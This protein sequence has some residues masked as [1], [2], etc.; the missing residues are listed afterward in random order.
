MTTTTDYWIE[1]TAFHEAGHTVM[2]LDLGWPIDFVSIIRKGDSGGR[3]RHGKS[4]SDGSLQ[5]IMGL[6]VMLSAGPIAANRFNKFM[7][8]AYLRAALRVEFAAHYEEATPRD[9]PEELLQIT[10]ELVERRWPAIELIARLLLERG[11]LSG[12]AVRIAV[13]RDPLTFASAS[14]DGN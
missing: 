14:G 12:E 2:A 4:T 3:L 10:T 9:V 7:P 6:F 13:E 8:D 1:E 5:D 11:T